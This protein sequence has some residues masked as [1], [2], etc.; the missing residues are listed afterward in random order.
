M[1]TPSVQDNCVEVIAGDDAKKACDI[2]GREPFH[3]R[4]TNGPP[5]VDIKLATEQGKHE[6]CESA[7]VDAVGRSAAEGFRWAG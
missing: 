7:G 2:A 3:H 4:F 5:K 6:L 1:G